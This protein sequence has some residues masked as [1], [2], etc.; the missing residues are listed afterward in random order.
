MGE[1]VW[2]AAS[3]HAPQLLTRPPQEDKT[4]L[5]AG[6]TAMA[7][8]GADL[9]ATKPDALIVLGIDHVETFFPGSVPAFAIVTGEMATAE[10]AG[11]KYEIPI[12]Q[13]LARGLLDGLIEQG[14][15]IAYTHEAL[16]GHAFAVPFEF[17][18]GGRPIPVIPMF[19]NVYLPPLPPPRRCMEVGNAIAKVI[20]GRPERVAILASGGMSHYPGTSKYFD[21]EYE[22]DR[23]VI[24]ELE[25]GRSESLLD[26]TGV[27]LD[28]TGDTE[29]LTWI[30][31]LGATGSPKG[32]LL[33]YQP[34]AHHG[35][36]VVR[37]KPARAERG[38][39]HQEM[40]KYGGFKF[41]GE[42]YQYYKYPTTET[43]PLNR[44]LATLKRD[45]ELRARFVRDM[46]GVILEFGLSE[47]E[48][49]ALKTFSTAA[50]VEQGGHGI[51]S[52]STMLAVQMSA[53]EAGIDI[54][55][56]A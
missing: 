34:T 21:P 9:D 8:L 24:Q 15:D 41:R 29:L 17:I 25:E 14:I 32:E 11:N 19:V 50:L 45:G 31:A 1:I 6:I 51:L 10:F 36:A 18:H 39:A 47:A 40:P 13:D 35:H 12:H 5:E 46:D 53:K 49:A 28:E 54:N 56:V 42:G 22:F 37:F 7:E 48:G 26:L 20:E 43:F 27:H 55:A 33:S 16:L 38:Q 30:V 4:Q 52:L 2:A 23:W 3:M 44:A